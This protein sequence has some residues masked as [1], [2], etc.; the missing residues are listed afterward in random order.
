MTPFRELLKGKVSRVYWDNE[1]QKCFEKTKKE[2][3]T[4]IASGLTFYDQSRKTAVV[5]DWSRE[6][7]GFI[8][9]QQHCA[10]KSEIPF[11]CESGWKFVFCGSRRLLPNEVNYSVP[12]GEALAI[13]WALQKARLF[14]GSPRFHCCH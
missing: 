13:A 7:I 3:C 1:L 9:L 12:E 2:I 10:C 8:I 4:L 5:T 14:T 11:C 6:G